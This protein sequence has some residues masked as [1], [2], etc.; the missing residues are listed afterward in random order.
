M[1]ISIKIKEEKNVRKVS[2][3]V[4][5][6]EHMTAVLSRE[7]FLFSFPDIEHLILDQEHGMPDQV[8]HTPDQ[9]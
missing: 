6:K 7:H 4:M 9:K 1:Q 5:E 3:E 8:Q 2:K